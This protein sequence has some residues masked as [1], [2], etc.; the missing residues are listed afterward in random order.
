MG[1]CDL[2]S[3]QPLYLHT[4]ICTGMC[5]PTHTNIHSSGQKQN[6]NKIH[7]DA[8]AQIKTQTYTEPKMF[9]LTTDLFSYDTTLVRSS[10]V[11]WGQIYAAK[12]T[13]LTWVIN[14]ILLKWWTGCLHDFLTCMNR[15]Y[16][17]CH[18]NITT[19]CK[20]MCCRRLR[21]LT[22]E[23]KIVL[24]HLH[25]SRH[26]HLTSPDYCFYSPDHVFT[27]QSALSSLQVMEQTHTHTH[28]HTHTH[29]HKHFRLHS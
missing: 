14:C 9:M 12:F 26:W 11:H 22:L 21:L 6:K 3:K 4:D 5:M 24:P 1:K 19:T 8:T 10:P 20:F 16:A 17:S 28:A 2:W 7:T 18:Y 13:L 23:P 25:C 29:T 15:G 27:F